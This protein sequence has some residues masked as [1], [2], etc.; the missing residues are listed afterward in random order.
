MF[1]SSRSFLG[2]WHFPLLAPSNNR[3]WRSGEERWP[4]WQQPRRRFTIEPGATRRRAV[5]NT[6]LRWKGNEDGNKHRT[7]HDTSG[8]AGPRN[9][10][11]KGSV[12]TSS[13]AF[14]GRSKGWGANDGRGR[15]DLL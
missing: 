12:A 14:R 4:T 11:L 6:T 9:P 2:R 15:R 1:D 5:V 10:L 8:M 3:R 13:Q 7:T